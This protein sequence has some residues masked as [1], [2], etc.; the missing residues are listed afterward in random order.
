MQALSQLSYGP[1]ALIFHHRSQPNHIAWAFPMVRARRKAA[2]AQFSGA[3]ARDL[4]C[5]P[6]LNRHP[7]R[8]SSQPKALP[9][10]RPRSSP[11]ALSKA[12]VHGFGLGCAVL[13]TANRADPRR[14]ATATPT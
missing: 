8:L 13:D 14:R 6:V 4:N 12:M 7:A 9:D 3:A 10:A 1:G 2:G 11:P 5:N